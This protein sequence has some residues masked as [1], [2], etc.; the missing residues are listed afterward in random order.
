MIRRPPRS[1]LFPYTTLFRSRDVRRGPGGAAPPD[2]D[3]VHRDRAETLGPGPAL[4]DRRPL[5][6]DLADAGHLAR[7]QGGLRSAALPEAA[8]AHR[9]VPPHAE[10]QQREDRGRAGL[11]PDLRAVLPPALSPRPLGEVRRGV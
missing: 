7:V 6:E 4:R 10:L 9:A 3:R 5:L 1:T 11:D 2:G 8:P